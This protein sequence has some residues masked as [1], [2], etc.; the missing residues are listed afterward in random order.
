MNP[1][2]AHL[3][4]GQQ[5]LVAV[6]QALG[7][8]GAQHEVQ[9]A[10]EHQM[11]E[12]FVLTRSL[13]VYAWLAYQGPHQRACFPPRAN[14]RLWPDILFLVAAVASTAQI[15]ARHRLSS[16]PRP[17]RWSRDRDGSQWKPG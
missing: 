3:R 10:P 14:R 6:C 13:S 9:S 15:G 2:V 4:R 7:K 5:A 12:S 8:N 17:G 1:R 11:D 16:P